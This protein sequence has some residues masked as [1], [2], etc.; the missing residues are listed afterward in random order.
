MKKEKEW[1]DGGSICNIDKTATEE[2]AEMSN[3]TLRNGSL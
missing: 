3:K 1:L 2:D